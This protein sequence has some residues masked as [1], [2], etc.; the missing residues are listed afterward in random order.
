MFDDWQPIETAPKSRK[1]F[2]VIAKDI[3][4]IAGSGYKYTSDPY[5]VWRHELEGFVRWPH[6]YPPTHWFPLPGV[7]YD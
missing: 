1:M 3:C 4:P 2:V 7:I 6:P 5:C